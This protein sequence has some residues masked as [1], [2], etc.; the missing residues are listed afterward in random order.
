LISAGATA[1]VDTS[2]PGWLD[3]ARTATGGSPV[4][5]GLNALGG[6]EGADLAKLLA[7]GATLVTYGAMSREPFTVSNAALIFRDLHVR[8]FWVTRWLRK[9]NRAERQELFSEIFG[10]IKTGLLHTPVAQ[11]YDLA[12]WRAALAHAQRPARKGKILFQLS[13]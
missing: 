2:Q 8:G 9:A 13:A 11:V 3:A 4:R 7:E 12:D 10:M 5:L 1:V 6:K